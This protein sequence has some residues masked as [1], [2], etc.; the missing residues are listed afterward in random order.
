MNFLVLIRIYDG[1]IVNVTDGYQGSEV[2]ITIWR[3]T[4]HDDMYFWESMLG[5]RGFR[6]ERQLIVPK[7]KLG[8]HLSPQDKNF[9]ISLQSYRAK[10]EQINARIKIF[11]CFMVSWT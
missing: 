4:I 6:G 10:I 11:G 3:N 8:Q 1:M 5:D 9:N 2:D 7:G